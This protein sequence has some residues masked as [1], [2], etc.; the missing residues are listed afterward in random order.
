[1]LKEYSWIHA[2]SLV[3]KPLIDAGL[4]LALFAKHNGSLHSVFL[5]IE[6]RDDGL[7]SLKANFSS[8]PWSL[9][10]GNPSLKHNLKRHIKITRRV[11]DN[12]W[13]WIACCTS[14]KIGV[15]E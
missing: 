6:K 12:S 7:Y 13:T 15:I 3:I 1:M 14:S 8:L 2:M 10:L 11:R 9:R 5:K 4:S